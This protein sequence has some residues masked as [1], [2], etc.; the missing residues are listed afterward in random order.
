MRTYQLQVQEMIDETPTVVYFSTARSA[1]QPDAQAMAE[2]QA[3]R[4]AVATGRAVTG[5]AVED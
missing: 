5:V 1:S 3:A 2:G 4:F